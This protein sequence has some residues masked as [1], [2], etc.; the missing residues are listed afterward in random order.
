MLPPTRE[1]P[2]SLFDL[3]HTPIVVYPGHLLT[4]VESGRPEVNRITICEF[5]NPKAVVKLG[6]YKGIQGY[7][8]KTC[9]RKLKDD[10]TLFHVKTHQS[11]STL[12]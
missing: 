12:S 6:T 8:C 7:W 11:K 10:T 9:N 5:C 1:D 3:P 4:I 2:T